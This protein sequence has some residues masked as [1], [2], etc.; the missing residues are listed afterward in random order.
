MSLNRIMAL[1]TNVYICEVTNLTEARYYAGMEVSMIGFNATPGAKS[2]STSVQ[3][4]AIT[5]WISGIKTVWQFHSPISTEFKT[6]I[7]ESPSDYIELN[8]LPK[9]EELAAITKPILIRSHSNELFKNATLEQLGAIDSIIWEG[10]AIEAPQIEGIKVFFQA[11]ND[12]IVENFI[13]ENP[14]VGIALKGVPELRP[15][16]NDFDKL[17]DILEALETV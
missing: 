11:A 3:F 15:G 6:L 16:W 8:Y 2:F 1:K 12:L 13:I 14:N 4:D 5:S 10:S 17:A 7:T 9:N